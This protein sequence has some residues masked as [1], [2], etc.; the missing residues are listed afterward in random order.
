MKSSSSL[1]PIIEI[2][3]EKNDELIFKMFKINIDDEKQNLVVC[4]LQQC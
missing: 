2:N 4:K 1:I 3:K